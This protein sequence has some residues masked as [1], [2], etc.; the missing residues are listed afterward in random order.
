MVFSVPHPGTDTAHREWER[1]EAGR[2]R[3]LKLDG[4]FETGP[5]MC[6]WN[7]P[8]LKYSWSTPYWRYTLGEWAELA[9][10]AGFTI[11]GLRE[12]RPTPMQIAA[13]PHLDD[14]GRMPFFLIFD[15][16]KGT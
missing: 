12:P 16:L 14:C 1:D 10:G 2:K 15:L 3:F 7:M 13:N 6:D 9:A 4:Y 11:K 8:R 5:S